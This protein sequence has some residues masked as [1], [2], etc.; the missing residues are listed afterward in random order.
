MFNRL[1]IKLKLGLSIL[2]VI[3]IFSTV[4]ILSAL[5]FG[6]LVKSNIEDKQSWEILALTSELQET[7]RSLG[8][9]MQQST[10]SPEK[11]FEETQTETLEKIANVDSLVSKNEKQQALLKDIESYV[12]EYF[13]KVETIISTYSGDETELRNQIMEATRP[14][15]IENG[16]I[17]EDEFSNQLTQI[18]EIEENELIDREKNA[19]Q[20]RKITFIQ[21]IGGTIIGAIISLLIFLTTSRSVVRN[22]E[23]TSHMLKD[24][25]EGEGDLTKRLEVKSKDE[26]GEMTLWFNRFIEKIHCLVEEVIKNSNELYQSTQEVLHSIE[27]SNEQMKE[28]ATSVEFVSSNIQSS[29]TVSEEAIASIQEITGQAQMIF[30]E[31]QEANETGEKVLTAASMG[32]ISVND[33]VSAI[34]NVQAS[35]KDVLK[36]M[37]ELKKSSKEIE[38]IVAMITQ[39]TEQTSLL[40]LNAS[41][42]A[43]RAGEAGKGFAVVADEVK[44]LSEESKN[45]AQQIHHI[46]DEIQQKMLETDE[47]IMK[48]QS[49]IQASS[50]KV[51]KTS[52]EFQNILNFIESISGKIGAMTGA[53]QNQSTITGDMTEAVTT[54][55]DGL[56]EHAATSQDISTAVQKQTEIYKDIEARM[57]NMKMI[58]D[59][60]KKQTDRFKI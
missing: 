15:E 5:N 51:L 56:Q 54:L 10:E 40:S 4:A 53:S 27:K 26:I 29:A 48:E 11:V 35:S 44:K 57:E 22:I 41:I 58:S 37:R 16:A 13:A 3:T 25:A 28:V 1:S 36:V 30:A 18:A 19:E 7:T 2:M 8:I 42:E 46:V 32:E 55:S 31:A 23:N 20:L 39:I 24:I 14:V 43:A 38:N 60:L 34:H 12:N 49:F 45:S 6:K 59:H 21:L 52:E 9:T 47:I 17:V 33:A 50:E